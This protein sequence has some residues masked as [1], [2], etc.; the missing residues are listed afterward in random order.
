M[1][2]VGDGSVEILDRLARKGFSEKMTFQV[3]N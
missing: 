2:G 1:V 3:K